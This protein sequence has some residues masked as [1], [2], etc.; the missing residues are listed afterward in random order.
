MLSFNM[1]CNV[2][3]ITKNKTK[4]DLTSNVLKTHSM[5][6]LSLTRV[7]IILH[8]NTYTENLATSAVGFCFALFGSISSHIL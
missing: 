1:V 5:F 4:H 2:F 8:F 6:D 7:E 3:I